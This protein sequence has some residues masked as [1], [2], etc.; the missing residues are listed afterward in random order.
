MTKQRNQYH[1]LIKS[2]IQSEKSNLLQSLLKDLSSFDIA[3]AML[4]LKTKYQVQVIALLPEE[5]ASEVLAEMSS[6]SLPITELVAELPPE[7]LGGWVG[8]MPKDDAADF[9]GLMDAQQAD[10]VLKLL[11][12]QQRE[13][14]TSLLQYAQDTA[15]G[16]MNPYV[17]AVQKEQ[18]VEEAIRSIRQYIEM[19]SSTQPFYTVYVVDEFKHLTG[20]VAVTQLL[21][22]K[23]QTLISEMMN[24]D[25]IAVDVDM[26]QEDVVQ[27][28]KEYDLVVVPVIDKYLRLIGRI[29]IDDLVDVIYKEHQEDIAQI[30]GT[31]REEVLEVSLIKTVRERL[32]WLMLGILGG[33][34]TALVMRGFEHS[35]IDIPQVTYFVPLIAAMAG[36]IGIQSSSIVVRGLAT[37]AIGTGDLI[38]RVWRELRVGFLLGI[39]CSI[40]L[41]MMTFLLT[42]N[43]GMAVITSVALLIV[44]CFAAMVGSAV[45]ILLEQVNIDPAIAIGPFITSMNDLIGVWIYLTIAFQVDVWL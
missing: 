8:E 33:S 21:L 31:A 41:G 3:A 9:V 45:P 22:G 17:I 19:Q 44:L 29:T 40:V 23:R 25:V 1:R 7:Q 28:A 26:D 27:I 24:P 5:R 15:G 30:S 18:S 36:S 16:I 12:D 43:L 4:Q 10:E 39:A 42:W 14:I 13:E 38:F 32:P 11:P 20:T 2:L 37:G 6:T 34:L 35:L